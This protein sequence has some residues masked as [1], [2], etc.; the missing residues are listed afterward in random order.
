MKNILYFT[1][2]EYERDTSDEEY[3]EQDISWSLR[4][5]F[6]NRPKKTFYIEEVEVDFVPE[7]D[8]IVYVVYVRYRTGHSLGHTTGVWNI[9]GTYKD[10]EEAKKVIQSIEDDTY[11]GHKPW[12]GHFETLTL[13]DFKKMIVNSS[14]SKH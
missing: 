2:D 11:E 7:T 8:Q 12:K 14:K 13:C 3:S 1:Y 9:I 5:C 10:E 4:E 6:K